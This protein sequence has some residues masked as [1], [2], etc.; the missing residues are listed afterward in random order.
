MASET[1]ELKPCRCGLAPQVRAYGSARGDMV[2][3]YCPAC[4]RDAGCVVV[5]VPRDLNEAIGRAAA[6]WNRRADNG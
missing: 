4:G 5:E 3:I 6:A 2:E 1:T